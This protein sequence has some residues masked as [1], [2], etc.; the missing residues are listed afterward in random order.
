VQWLTHALYKLEI[1]GRSRMCGKA[2][3]TFSGSC[4]GGSQSKVLL[5][6]NKREI[7][8]RSREYTIAEEHTHEGKV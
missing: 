2:D 6:I 8:T 1:N 5:I 4:R 7:F 3:R